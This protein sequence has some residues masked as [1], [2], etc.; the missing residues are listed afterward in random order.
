MKCSVSIWDRLQIPHNLTDLLQSNMGA[1]D[2][3]TEQ[4]QYRSLLI[5]TYPPFLYNQTLQRPFRPSPY[6][7]KHIGGRTDRSLISPSFFLSS[8]FFYS[9][10]VSVHLR[11]IL[12]VVERLFCKQ[13]TS[14]IKLFDANPFIASEWIMQSSPSEAVDAGCE[15]FFWKGTGRTA[16]G[17]DP[18]L[19][20]FWRKGTVR[21]NHRLKFSFIILISD[22]VKYRFQLVFVL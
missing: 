8:P 21:I 20:L 3:W 22:L 15:L 9:R 4:S 12:T 11:P 5:P 7:F 18:M 14:Q 17:D 13:I 6:L 16:V 2:P 19:V 10:A 1:V